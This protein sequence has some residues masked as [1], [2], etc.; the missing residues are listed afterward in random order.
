MNHSFI[1]KIE[2]WIKLTMKLRYFRN[3]HFQKH[4]SILSIKLEDTNIPVDDKKNIYI[5]SRNIVF[6]NK[7][8]QPENIYLSMIT[9][10]L[11]TS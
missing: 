11:L 5:I 4:T 3:G 6:K 1:A 2:N 7:D 8:I 9:R 10:F